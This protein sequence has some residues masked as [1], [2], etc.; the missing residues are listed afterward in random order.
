[1]SDNDSCIVATW[2]EQAAQ[3]LQPQVGICT[4]AAIV[5]LFFLLNLIA[6]PNVR[7]RSMQWLYAY[8]MTDLLLLTRFFLLY[9]YRWLSLCLPHLL[10]ITICYCEAILDNY[11]NMLQSYI[12]LALNVCRYL[13][14]NRNYD[15]YKFRQRTIAVCHCLIYSL[16]LVAYVVS[17][18]CQWLI[19]YDPENDA[20]DVDMRSSVF[21]T[22]FLLFSFFIPVVLT[23]TFLLLSL[24]HVRNTNGM[25]TEQIIAARLRYHRRLVIQSI[26]FYSVWLLLWAPFL[27]LF[28]FYYK[29]TL[30]GTLAQTLSY[31]GVALDPI[32]IAALD[33]RLLQAWRSSWNRLLVC[34]RPAH[35]A[36]AVQR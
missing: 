28:P 11:L 12:L 27:L 31:V 17:V 10:Y 3:S 9:T 5:H 36:P 8:L 16:P 14:I 33:V 15:V 30:A 32:L 25:Q 21:E 1:M 24:K 29:H 26:V 34:L 20:C 19:L 6:Y 18:L 2:S 22:F 7:N 13:Q 4:G 35:V 23:L